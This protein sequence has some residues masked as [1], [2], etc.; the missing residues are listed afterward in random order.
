M[1]VTNGASGMCPLRY[2]EGCKTVLYCS[3]DCQKTAWPLHKK[4]CKQIA[5]EGR[6]LH[7]IPTFSTI[8]KLM[9]HSAA[10]TALSHMDKA[11]CIAYALYEYE[12]YLDTSSTKDGD[13]KISRSHAFGPDMR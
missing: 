3:R 10:L 11:N 13:D 9:H 2:C 8:S 1:C 12:Q 6:E 5:E 7:I 4:F